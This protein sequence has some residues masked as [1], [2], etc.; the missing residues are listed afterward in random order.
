MDR[1]TLLKQLGAA[2][3][4][5]AG[6]AVVASSPAFA[7]QASC[8]RAN[9]SYT[10][11][12]QCREQ[13]VTT[14]SCQTEFTNTIQVCRTLP[15]T[16]MSISRTSAGQGRPYFDE[17]ATFYVT[18]PTNVTRIQNFIGWQNNCRF[19]NPTFA[20]VGGF[21]SGNGSPCTNPGPFLDPYPITNL[22]GNE[23]GIFT[24]R[25]DIRNFATPYGYSTCFV[26]VG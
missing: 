26:R 5:T 25:V 14:S 4:A 19:P 1:R 22:F 9:R 16:P 2:G 10:L 3:V 8:C 24:V 17:V 20:D 7:A 13:S 15:T 23:C 12:G 6:T 21:G 18:S 11:I